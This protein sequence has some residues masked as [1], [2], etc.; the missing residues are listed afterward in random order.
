M[1]KL[2]VAYGSNLNKERMK[3]RCPNAKF[4]G[5]GVIE[6]YE[7][8]FKGS[9]YGAHATIAPKMGASVPVAIWSLR[10][11]DEKHLDYYEGYRKDGYCYYDKEKIRVHTGNGDRLVG[12]VYIMDRE[13]DFGLPV[14][15]FATVGSKYE[16]SSAIINN[17]T[18]WG[19]LKPTV[20]H[21]KFT[22]FHNLQGYNLDLGIDKIIYSLHS[23]FILCIFE[24]KAVV[25]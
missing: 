22:S 23:Q 7:L 25:F 24:K 2:Y 6:N 17:L 21:L 11:T 10:G 5:T 9:L 3:H 4:M 15:G 19:F 1:A 20:N 13:K 16:G 14:M 8:Q 18:S 12:M